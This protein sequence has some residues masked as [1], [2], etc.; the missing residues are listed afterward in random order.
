MPLWGEA[1]IDG[2]ILGVILIFVIY[3]IIVSVI[4]N[5]YINNYANVPNF[6]NVFVPVYA[7]YQL[8]MLRGTLMSAF[9]YFIPIV[10]F[11]LIATKSNKRNNIRNIYEM[12][13]GT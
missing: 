9:A 12:Y 2:G 7:A 11:L 10:M 4:E 5:I 3:G 8:F 13:Q 6:L 1:Y